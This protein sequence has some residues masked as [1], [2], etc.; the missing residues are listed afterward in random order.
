MDSRPDA[1]RDTRPARIDA[2]HARTAV[3]ASRAMRRS[4][5]LALALSACTLLGAGPRA[6]RGPRHGRPRRPR[7]SPRPSRP[8]ASRA[9]PRASRRTPPR[10]PSATPTSRSSSPG[11]TSRSAVGYT[12]EVS[13]TPASARSS[14]RATSTQAI[15]V[16][17]ILL[18]DGAYWWRVRAVD[19]AGT[20]ASGATSPASPRPG[21]TSSRGTRISATPGGAAASFTALNPYLSWNPV[22]G[23]KTYDVAGLPGRPVQQ[24]RLLR[25]QRAPSRSRRPARSGALPDDTYSWRVRARDPNDNPGPWTVGGSTFTKAW[26]RADA[27]DA[28]RR[29]RPTQQP[30][31]HWNP[32]DGAERYQVQITTR[33]STTRAGT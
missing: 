14:G 28:R 32:V 12:V 10:R 19:A 13:T 31:P 8:T 15:A 17:E 5:R 20:R 33:S 30:P 3:V 16:P 27:A 29:R 24:R 1:D 4:R 6:R 2:P 11:A 26:T 25:H 9:S 22:P 23:A 21:R 18:P 7:R